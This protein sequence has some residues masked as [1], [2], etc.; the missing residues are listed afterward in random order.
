M[1]NMVGGTAA[2]VYGLDPDGLRREAARIDAP[3]MA[4]ISQPLE[5]APAGASGFAFRTMG[6]WA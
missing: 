5:T 4:E 1:R 6:P 2:S 3:T